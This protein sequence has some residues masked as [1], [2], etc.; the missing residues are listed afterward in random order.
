MRADLTGHGHLSPFC[1]NRWDGRALLDQPSKG[2]PCRILILFPYCSTISLAPHIKKLETYFAL[3]Y[4]WTFAQCEII[5][6]RH[7]IGHPIRQTTAAEQDSST[8]STCNAIVEK[9]WGM[10]EA[11][12]RK[13]SGKMSKLQNA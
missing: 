5:L 3:L 11:I 10:S 6:I 7:N 1:Q 13:L 9:Y 8:Q 12:V 4:F 2:H